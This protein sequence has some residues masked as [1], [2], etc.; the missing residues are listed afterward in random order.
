MQ[1]EQGRRGAGLSMLLK[2]EQ[3]AAPFFPFAQGGRGGEG[4]GGGVRMA[5][6]VKGKADTEV[7]VCVSA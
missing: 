6:K 7:S 4:V 2:E 1:H 3:A 5:A